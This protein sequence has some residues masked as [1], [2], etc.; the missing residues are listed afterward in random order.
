MSD[1][2]MRVMDMTLSQAR[3]VVSRGSS[4]AHGAH[5]IS[6]NERDRV[7]WDSGYM[8]GRHAAPT[9]LVTSQRPQQAASLSGI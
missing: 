5:A 1:A 9:C 3:P 2:A 6:N 8:I 7:L 4:P